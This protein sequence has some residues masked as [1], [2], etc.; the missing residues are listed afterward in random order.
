MPRL[1]RKTRQSGG[2]QYLLLNY[3]K[4]VADNRLKEFLLHEPLP[5]FTLIEEFQNSSQMDV[6]G[7][8]NEEYIFEAFLEN[9]IS[10]L[11][12]NE[13]SKQFYFEADELLDKKTYYDIAK[14][15]F[16]IMETCNAINASKQ[17]I[18]VVRM[19]SDT[20]NSTFDTFEQSIK[21][22]DYDFFSAAEKIIP[23]KINITFSEG[24]IY[25]YKNTNSFVNTYSINDNLQ[26]DK[27]HY[28]FNEE[29]Y[30]INDSVLY[31]FFILS[32]YF[33]MKPKI[34]IS[35]ED[36]LNKFSRTMKRQKK[37]NTKSIRK[38]LEEKKEI[39]E[40]KIDG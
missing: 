31:L 32:N 38:L 20:Y 39:N 3:S 14:L 19:K 10:K 21:K 24:Y 11:F 15:C 37:K 7:T 5:F 1:L 17:D 4:K 2:T 30:F 8:A 28:D 25:F 13:E 18:D 29:L 35:S 12:D 6:I 23:S 34:H 33:Y 9:M 26:I 40:E 22:A 27:E 36:S 16:V